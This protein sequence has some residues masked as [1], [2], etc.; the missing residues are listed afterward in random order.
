MDR[1]QQSGPKCAD[2]VFS[3][4]ASSLQT[5]GLKALVSAGLLV[6][7]A[8]SKVTSPTTTQ[9][10][11]SSPAPAKIQ[12]WTKSLS[13][14]FSP[15]TPAPLTDAKLPPVP[16]APAVAASSRPAL[17][18]NPAA[19]AKE[20]AMKM[21]PALAVKDSTFN[22]TFRDLY[23]EESQKEPEFL[24]RADWPLVLAHRTAELLSRQPATTGT[25][26]SPAT[27]APIAVASASNTPDHTLNSFTSSLSPNP[28]DRG[29]YN[30][31]RSPWWYWNGSYY[32]YRPQTVPAPTP[33][34]STSASA[35][36]TNPLDRPA[37]NQN[38]SPWW[39]WGTYYYTP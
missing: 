30:Q 24:T 27:P 26:A 20:A 37:Y 13:S 35:P 28:L 18:P 4:T 3:H 21:Y 9:N 8:C 7:V 23:A 22:K 10:P 11:G 34:T 31:N 19:G 15:S 36:T 12:D 32:V 39:G 38:R 17:A 16:P 1:D 33:D 14:L 5:I 2:G 29:A 6:L 25:P